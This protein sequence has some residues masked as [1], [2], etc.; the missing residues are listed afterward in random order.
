MELQKTELK[1]LLV[2]ADSVWLEELKAEL[3]ENGF[4]HIETAQNGREAMEKVIN[5]APRVIVIDQ[6]LKYR[7]GLGVID[8]IREHK[9]STEVILTSEYLTYGLVHKATELGAQFILARPIEVEVVV[10]RIKDI[11]ALKML[12]GKKD[13]KEDQ[14]V[15]KQDEYELDEE[16]LILV[17]EVGLE[18]NIGR[19]LIGFEIRPHLKG[20][21]YLKAGIMMTLMNEHI[22][23]A[24]TKDLYPQLALR[25]NTT[26]TSVER[27]MRH[28]IE[29]AWRNTHSRY[30]EF[31]FGKGSAQVSQ[32]KKPN[33]GLFINTVAEKIRQNLKGQI[34]LMSI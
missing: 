4:M 20:Y 32:D 33:N 23:N 21:K 14:E 31:Y 25:Y 3:E 1:I 9:L 8:S 17:D 30:K 24:I 12:R 29:T 15:S 13:S 18:N 7:D 27:D 10:S 6:M 34:S 16:P 11:I 5:D 28:A 22:T 19:I 26:A 2:D